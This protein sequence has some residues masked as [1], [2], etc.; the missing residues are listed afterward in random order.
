MREFPKTRDTF[1]GVPHQ[2][3]EVI[4]PG[5]ILESPHLKLPSGARDQKFSKWMLL[6]FGFRASV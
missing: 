3:E 1:S 2:N 4:F 5:S 6:G